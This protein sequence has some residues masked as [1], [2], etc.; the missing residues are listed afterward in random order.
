MLKNTKGIILIIALC[1]CHVDSI[2]NAI[3]PG[4]SDESRLPAFGSQQWMQIDAKTS[5]NLCDDE[6][7]N[8]CACLPECPC[9]IQ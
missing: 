5:T 8:T 7:F 4:E 1:L 6:C 2:S 9:P 3:L